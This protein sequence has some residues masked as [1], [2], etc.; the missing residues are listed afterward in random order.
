MNFDF[1]NNSVYN[2]K[3]SK[4]INAF[5]PFHEIYEIHERRSC[6]N[7]PQY[8]TKLFEE[9]KELPEIIEKNLHLIDDKRSYIT[10]MLATR[11]PTAWV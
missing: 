3:I 4:S 9:P 8:S 7:K 1:N 10:R 11:L 2:A 5:I 6:Y